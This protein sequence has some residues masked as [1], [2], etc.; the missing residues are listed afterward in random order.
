MSEKKIEKEV[1]TTCPFTGQ[2]NAWTEEEFDNGKWKGTSLVDGSTISSENLE[3]LRLRY[4]K[5][6]M[7]RLMKEENG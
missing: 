3:G 2:E 7:A 6:T 1:Y 4:G 5:L